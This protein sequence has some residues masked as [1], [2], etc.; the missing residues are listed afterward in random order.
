MNI[1]LEMKNIT[2][3]FEEN[4]VV[5]DISFQVK[6]NSIV[7]L[8]GVNGSGKSTIMKLIANLYK[9]TSGTIIYKGKEL[10]KKNLSEMGFLIEN[11]AIYGG[12]SAYDNLKVKA[13]LFDIDESRIQEILNR[14]GLEGTGNKKAGKFSLGMKQRLGIGLALLNNPKLL[15]LDEPTNGLDPLGIIGL[16]KM[17]KSMPEEGKTVIISSHSLQELHNITDTIIMINKGKII[18]DGKID[19]DKDLEKLF[20]KLME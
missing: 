17:I 13:I 2:K 20:L 8:I 16:R 3:K 9:P 4:I 14:V 6:E 7:G 1:L 5:D 19:S 10:H 15:I 18:Y 11:P 12:L